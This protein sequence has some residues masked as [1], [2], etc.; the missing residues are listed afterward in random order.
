MEV[1]ILQQVKVAIELT[2]LEI[3]SSLLLAFLIEV[4]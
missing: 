4:C 1:I 2:T 3:E